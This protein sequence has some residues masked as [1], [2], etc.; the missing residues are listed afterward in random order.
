MLLFSFSGDPRGQGR[1][2]A[3]TRGGFATVYKDPKSRAYEGS[4]AR[5]AASYMGDRP[6]LTGAL[7][8]SLWFKM[9]I[10]VSLSKRLKAAMAA[11]EVPHVKVPDCSNLAKAV[12]DALNGIAW[13]D[14]CQI[15]RLFVTKAYS[16]KPGFTVRVE[17][18]EPQA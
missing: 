15:V 1:P 11:G 12:E 5:V 13:V 8:V 4:I 9:P 10:P 3:T 18:L 2:R 7:S 14:D 6:P 16:D 17:A